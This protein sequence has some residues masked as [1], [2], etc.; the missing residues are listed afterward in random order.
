M[1]LAVI[2][3]FF[4]SLLLLLSYIIDELQSDA[5][6]SRILLNECINNL[7]RLSYLKH[8]YSFI[9]LVISK[10]FLIIIIGICLRNFFWKRLNIHST[11]IS[12]HVI[13]IYMHVPVRCEK[14]KMPYRQGKRLKKKK[15]NNL[16]IS[17]LKGISSFLI[18]LII[19][20]TF[21][22]ALIYS[23]LCFFF[24]QTNK[25]NTVWIRLRKATWVGKSSKVK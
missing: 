6:F 21:L 2:Q 4:L 1:K 13:Y 9:F 15:K 25:K 18:F 22:H 19:I 12:Y 10:W 24:L 17:L 16:P 11:K 3:T 20:K 23:F 7:I 14:R 5:T 8:L